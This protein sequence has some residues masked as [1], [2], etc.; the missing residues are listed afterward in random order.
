MKDMQC[1]RFRR[2]MEHAQQDANIVNQ[3]KPQEE[4]LVLHIVLRRMS[5]FVGNCGAEVRNPRKRTLVRSNYG[6]KVMNCRLL[7]RIIQTK[8]CA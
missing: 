4:Q 1:K 8:I 5:R 7:E 6:Q 3:R 2:E